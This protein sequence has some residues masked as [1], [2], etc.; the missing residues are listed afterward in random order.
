MLSLVVTV[1]HNMMNM[2][3]LFIGNKI[4]SSIEELDSPAD[5]TLGIKSRKQ[6]NIGR[7]WDG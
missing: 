5:G 3:S 1:M 4:V 7:A 6:I 2:L